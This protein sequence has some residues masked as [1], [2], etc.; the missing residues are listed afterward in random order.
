MIICFELNT[1]RAIHLLPS[2]RGQAGIVLVVFATFR[3][4]ILD[5]AHFRMR[6]GAHPRRCG[7]VARTLP[8]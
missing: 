3:N 1:L 7:D 4:E 8:F 2:P 6:Q 5:R